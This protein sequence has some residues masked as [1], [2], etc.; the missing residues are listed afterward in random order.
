M[1]WNAAYTIVEAQVVGIYNLGVLNKEILE[2]IVKPFRGTDIDSGGSRD[3]KTKDEKS[4]EDV[5]IELLCP[6]KLKQEY[7]AMKQKIIDTNAELATNHEYEKVKNK[8]SSKDEYDKANDLYWDFKDME[9]EAF[10]KS[11]KW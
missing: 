3:L 8:F 6:E 11:T 7:F 2:Q 10:H 1:G 4:F 5:V 9:Y